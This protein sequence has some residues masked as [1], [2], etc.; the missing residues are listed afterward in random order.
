VREVVDNS[1]VVRSRYDYDPWGRRTKL[2]GDKDADVGYTGH[3][4]HVSSGLTLALFRAY[5]PNLGRWTSEDPSG[6]LDGPNRFAYVHG[7]PGSVYDPLGLD[8]ITIGPITIPLPWTRT[9][10][11]PAVNAA[12]DAHEAQHRADWRKDIPGWE[13]EQRGFE[14]EI[15]ILSKRLKELQDNNGPKKSLDEVGEAL[16][17]ARQYW[18]DTRPIYKP[19]EKVPNDPWLPSKVCR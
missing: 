4:Q 9:G 8:S 3:Y 1:N 5:D 18:N 15:P 6:L 2:S 12:E 17:T 13:K 10:R 14:R 19:W 16:D 11:D 7:N